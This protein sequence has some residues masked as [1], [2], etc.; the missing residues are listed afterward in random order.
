M[1]QKQIFSFQKSQFQ[2]YF[3]NK[4]LLETSLEKFNEYYKNGSGCFPPTAVVGYWLALSY[5]MLDHKTKS[6]KTQLTEN[7]RK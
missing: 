6:Q 2:I 7:L 5:W 4:I 3:K 1:G